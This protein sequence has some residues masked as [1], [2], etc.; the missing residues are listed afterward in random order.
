M[1]TPKT[2]K[3]LHDT[4]FAI[5]VDTYIKNII[6]LMG[7]KNGTHCAHWGH[8]MAGTLLNIFPFVDKESITNK[9]GFDF[10]KL[11]GK[12]DGFFKVTK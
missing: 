4:L 5:D 1:V 2:D 9:V 3:I 7:I 8:S 6:R 10:A 12:N 11:Y